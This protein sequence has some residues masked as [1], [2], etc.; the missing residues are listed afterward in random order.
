MT[1]IHNRYYSPSNLRNSVNKLYQK[2]NGFLVVPVMVYFGHPLTILF[3]VSDIL[4]YK[5]LQSYS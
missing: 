1:S 5:P 2:L 4:G 3:I